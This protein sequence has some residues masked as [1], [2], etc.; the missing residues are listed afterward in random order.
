[1][2]LLATNPLHHFYQ[3]AFLNAWQKYE[4]VGHFITFLLTFLPK[5][6]ICDW[7]IKCMQE[8]MFSLIIDMS[9]PWRS[10]L[11]GLRH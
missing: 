2:Y 5:G 4:T 8:K 9:T 7:K 3:K 11:L 6:F 10:Q 1:M